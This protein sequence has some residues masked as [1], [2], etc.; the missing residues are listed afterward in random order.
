M[1]NVLPVE[2]EGMQEKHR[3]TNMP[4]TVVH[5]KASYMVNSIAEKLNSRFA[6]ALSDAGLR[7]WAG[8]STKWMAGRFSDAYIHETLIAHIRRALDHKFPRAS[9][10]E[11]FRQFRN[12]MDKAEGYLNSEDFAAREYGGLEALGKD[13][14]ERCRADISKG[15]E[16]LSK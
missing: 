8:D 7:S 15:G 6:A 14:R 10:G 12:R 9:P 16:R 4:R 11:T 5:D 3:W 1:K 13:L 2:L